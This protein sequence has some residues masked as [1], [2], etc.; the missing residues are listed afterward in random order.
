MT[1][2]DIVAEPLRIHRLCARA[3]ERARIAALLSQTGLGDDVLSRHPHELSG[4]QRQRVGIARALAVEPELLICDEPVSALD[5]SVRAQVVNLLAELRDA[6]GLTLLFIAHDLAVVRHLSTRVAVMYLGKI[7]EQAPTATLF[8]TP[9]HPYTKALW[10]AA[11]APDP[12]RRRTAPVVRGEPASALAPPP[13]CAF[14]P[15][16][17]DAVDRCRVEAPALLQ[18]GEAQV[19]CHLATP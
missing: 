13:G 8:A 18:I 12:A 9:R 15:R 14:H 5:A 2:A 19:A 10:A 1:I 6:R 7:V 4:G 17:P 16:C 3:D 11:P